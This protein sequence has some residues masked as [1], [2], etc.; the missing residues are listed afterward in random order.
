MEASLLC[1]KDTSI[2]HTSAQI[3]SIKAIVA[4]WVDAKVFDPLAHGYVNAGNTSIMLVVHA[5][6][7]DV[8]LTETLQLIDNRGRITATSAGAPLLG[9]IAWIK[10]NTGLLRWVVST[11][12]RKGTGW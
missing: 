7:G 1:G 3:R 6:N 5:P 10:H 9:D 2:I 8:N 4:Q 11:T 12:A